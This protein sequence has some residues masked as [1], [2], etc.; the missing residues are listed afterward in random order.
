MKCDLLVFCAGFLLL[1]G[2]GS[3][4]KNEQSQSGI[5]IIFETDMGND[6]DDALALDLLF[7]YADMGLV[8]FLGVST[9]KESPYSIEFLDV[10]K[11]WYGHPNLPLAK[12]THGADCENDAINYAKV[13][14]Q[15]LEG[16]KSPFKRTH[17]DY[18]KIPESPQFYRSVLS[19]QPDNSVIVVSVGFS[20]NIAR[21]LDTQ[22]DAFSPLTGKE[23][24]AKKVKFLSMM[25]GNMADGNMLEYNVVRD[26]PAARKVFDEW[27]T[28]IVVS[29]FELGVTILFPAT[30]IQDELAKTMPNPL[31]IAYESYGKMPYNKETW[32]LTSVLFA[33]EGARNYFS[34]SEKGRVTVDAEGHTWFQSD[35]NGKHTYLIVNNEQAE[36]IKNRFVELISAKPKNK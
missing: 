18:G 22:P 15:Y 5:P 12:I 32:D 23:L 11:T 17:Q 27:P 31:K 7:K 10:M 6:V 33:V 20:T 30:V 9:N 14:C 2:C 25:A 26:V 13:T 28:P 16:G 3:S 21:L 34:V 19:K 35:P 4:T 29:P 1:A 8:N 24:V 36:N